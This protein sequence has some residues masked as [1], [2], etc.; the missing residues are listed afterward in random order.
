[1]PDAWRDT[2]HDYSVRSFLNLENVHS[3]KLLAD[4]GAKLVDDY[5]LNLMTHRRSF[6]LFYMQSP[7][8]PVTELA[9]LEHLSYKTLIISVSDCSGKIEGQSLRLL[10]LIC[11]D[12][13][14]QIFN[15]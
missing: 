4:L 2:R 6:D 5:H 8:L 9:I 15:I 7:P 3:L 10:I 12:H 13:Q 14:K 1:M 11:L